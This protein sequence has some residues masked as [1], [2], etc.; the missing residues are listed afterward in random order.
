MRYVFKPPF[1]KGFCRLDGQKLVSG[2]SIE[3][4][5]ERLA[6]MPASTR[7]MFQ[8]AEDEPKKRGR[9]TKVAPPPGVEE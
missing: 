6:A 5:A 7:E 1:D 9:P 8:P 3:L 2:E 4:T